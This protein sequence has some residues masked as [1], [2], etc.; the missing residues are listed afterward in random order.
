MMLWYYMTSDKND[1]PYV[2]CSSKAGED[3]EWP[4][5]LS[6][7]M[8]H[9]ELLDSWYECREGSVVASVSWPGTLRMM[10]SRGHYYYYTKIHM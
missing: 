3:W 7:L 10:D 5:F 8:F 9:L 1:S 2:S 4:N 6:S